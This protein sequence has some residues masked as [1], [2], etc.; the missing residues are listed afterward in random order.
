VNSRT[1]QPAFLVAWLILWGAATVSYAEDAD[2]PCWRG[3]DGNG[4]SRETGWKP[5]ALNG[6]PKVLWKANVLEGYSS[7]AVRGDRLFTMGNDGENDL[8]FCL[9]V[10]NGEEL[11][12]F[13]CP[14]KPGQYKGP[15]ATPAVD[16]ASVYVMSRKGLVHRLDAKTGKRKWRI[17]LD[18]TLQAKSCTW[19]FSCSPRLEG[20]LL[21]LNAGKHGVALNK[22]NGA[23]CWST[24]GTGG[25]A[26]PVVFALG[27]RKGVAVFSKGDLFIVDL[28]S[29]RKLW[30]LD[31]KTEYS[32]NA[33]DPVAWQDWIFITSGYGR[34]CAGIEMKR[35]RFRKAWENK[36]IDSHFQSPVVLDGFVYGIGGNTGDSRA[37]LKCLNITTGAVQWS[38]QTGWS[39]LIAVD[40]RLVVLGGQGYL[41]VYEASPKA[42]KTVAKSGRLEKSNMLAKWWTP[43][44]LCRGRLYCRSSAGDLYCIDVRK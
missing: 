18:K 33:A 6:M 42:C 35:G 41:T 27:R 20:K 5:E 26:S 16:D 28:K 15:R 9:K 7:V 32:V 36:E 25:Y 19:G 31:W 39:S 40:G 23:R 30:S 38:E 2:W 10:E 11:W 8:V 1:A 43:P 37:C 34:G 17:D 24:P 44:A 29:G 13:S 12:R 4:V 22:K 21:L 3:P 14:C